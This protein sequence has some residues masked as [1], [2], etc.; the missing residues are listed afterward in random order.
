MKKRINKI[1]W[2]GDELQDGKAKEPVVSVTPDGLDGLN[3]GEVF[4]ANNEAD[5]AIFIRTSSGKVARI[6]GADLEVLKKLFLSKTTD[7]TAE[8]KIT[9]KKGLK[10]EG[11]VD[12]TGESSLQDTRFGVYTPSATGAAILKDKDGNWLI[13]TDNLL[14]R[15][16]ATFTE[17]E[18][19]E[20]HHVGGQM[21]LT[22][23]SATVV[24]V[25]E[26]ENGWRCYF[27]A[28]DSDGLAIENQWKEGDQAFCNTFN[29]AHNENGITGNHYL[30]RAVTNTGEGS[31]TVE[32]DGVE[33]DLSL[34]HYIELSSSNAASNSDAP[35]IGDNLVQL[36]YQGTDDSNRQN[37]IIIA[38]AGA[39]SPY[40]YQF[41]GINSFMLPEPETRI[42]P[43][44]NLFSG[45]M[46]LKAGSTIDGESILDK[47][48]NADL[49]AEEYAKAEAE[50]ARIEAEAFADGKITD[51]EKKL[52]ADAQTKVDEAKAELEK[53]TDDSIKNARFGKY[54]L[55][56][57]SGF[58]G[59]Y[60]TTQLD[61]KLMDEQSQLFSDPYIHWTATNA[62]VQESEVS[63]SEYEMKLTDGS[64]SQELK[65]PIINGENYVFSLKAKTGASGGALTFSVGG[66]S[67]AIQLSDAY[68]SYY[69]YFKA[70]SS[71][72]VFTLSSSDATVCELQLERGT[73]ASAWGNSMWDNQSELAQY[74]ALTYLS[75]AIKNSSTETL[76]GLFMADIIMCG[77][78]ND[79][80]VRKITSGMSGIYSASEEAN[81]AFWAG[82]S[83]EQAI[84]TVK[85]FA[86]DPSYHPTEEEWKSLASY[87]VTHEGNAFIR[88]YIYALGGIFKGTVYA[89]GG[90]FN[91]VTAKNIKAEDSEFTGKVT[92]T[93]GTIGGWKIDGGS[94][95]S[96]DP[97]MS[98]IVFGKGHHDNV[99]A[100]E[101]GVEMGAFTQQSDNDY[102]LPM[103]LHNAIT[104][105]GVSRQLPV[106]HYYRINGESGGLAFAGYGDGMLNGAIDG[107]R[108]IS[109]EL[110]EANQEVYVNF[111]KEN[112]G[113]RFI[114]YCT[115]SS[116]SIILPN[117][118]NLC[119]RFGID[120]SQPFS[121]RMSIV[122]G[123]RI[124]GGNRVGSY[125]TFYVYGRGREGV[126][127][128][129]LYPQLISNGGSEMTGGRS[130]GIGD[131]LELMLTYD[132]G[133]LSEPNTEYS[134]QAYLMNYSS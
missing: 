120:P 26:S 59:D 94:I 40:I 89:N 132:G 134:Y 73:I 85:K 28:E 29:I 76:G 92:A 46:R 61:D 38:G 124:E 75:D 81:V 14:V 34:C 122:A 58:T 98:L 44:N 8:G 24:Y 33:I 69:I 101:M 107:Y 99:G 42:K 65:M 36:G 62:T 4:I 37:A 18:I 52:I 68:T 100:G 17:V 25:A 48:T 83:L 10:S 47:F 45:F 16:K 117:F 130:M 96:E 11:D 104:I 31:E 128:G 23:A 88:G 131:T 87:V 49:A 66:Y 57:N 41:T 5:P 64:L 9:F 15:K 97:T 51:T 60:V 3:E 78:S 74:Q 106:G 115:N 121:V 119:S 7:D 109:Y 67:E 70:V 27:R 84:L 125:S 90:E 93:S 82:G 110:T 13:E 129:I 71:D 79:D 103:R 133:N 127:E 77:D 63:Q 32:V 55:L 102:L 118:W 108:A 1:L 116:G 22:A 113:N 126:S 86:A 54:N 50:K 6:G 111:G 20:V 2:Y 12:V 30:W 91:N 35:K 105:K 43:G 56:R 21:L 95:K 123:V 39:N 80:E 72:S 19:Q 53:Y 114:I 112:G